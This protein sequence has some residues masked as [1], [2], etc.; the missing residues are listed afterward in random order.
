M[1]SSS[2]KAYY[3]CRSI[4]CNTIVPIVAYNNNKKPE[5]VKYKGTCTPHQFSFSLIQPTR[6]LSA[7]PAS[8]FVNLS[9]AKTFKPSQTLKPIPNTPHEHTFRMPP[10]TRN[11]GAKR[12]AAPKISTKATAKSFKASK[13]SSKKAATWT[14]L[15]K[16]VV[17]EL[18]SDWEEVKKSYATAD[19]IP[20]LDDR[21]TALVKRVQKTGKARKSSKKEV[22]EFESLQREINRQLK[23]KA[24]ISNGMRHSSHASVSP[25]STRASTLEG[26]TIIVDVPAWYLKATATS[27]VSKNLSDQFTSSTAASSSIPKPKPKPSASKN[28][29]D[30]ATSSSTAMPSLSKRKRDPIAEPEELFLRPAKKQAASRSKVLPRDKSDHLAAKKR[31]GNEPIPTGEVVKQMADLLAGVSEDHPKLKTKMEQLQSLVSSELLKRDEKTK[32]QN[33]IA[34]HREL[35]DSYEQIETLERENQQL[36]EDAADHASEDRLRI[37][38]EDMNTKML[39]AQKEN[40]ELKRK[41]GRWVDEKK[42]AM[43]K[44]GGNNA[45][46]E[47]EIL[48][49]GRVKIRRVAPTRPSLLGEKQGEAGP[50][51]K[52]RS[53]G[54]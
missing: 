5:T 48:V 28:L 21:L 30:P 37:Q 8:S 14:Q 18:L 1:G 17:S 26:D 40:E 47:N 43:M 10:T 29:S 15:T 36:L 34:L 9:I 16:E 38:L 52:Q 23:A 44:D 19:D 50:A 39:K 4:T 2:L 24:S 31:A 42:G 12:Q 13:T 46:A 35:A 3:G 25:A 20:Q 53:L 45:L 27:N 54:V 11:T 41:Y 32:A 6:K 33:P 49:D 51:A 22:D 7:I